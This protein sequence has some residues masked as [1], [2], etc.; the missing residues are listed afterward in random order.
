MNLMKNAL[1]LLL[2]CLLFSF[3]LA[4]QYPTKSLQA[5]R[6]DVPEMNVDGH[7][8]EPF[9]QTLE[10]HRDFVQYEPIENAAP[11]QATAF[12][13]AYDDNFIY[14]GFKAYDSSPD[15]IVHRLTRR[16][17]IDGDFVGVQFDSYF[18][19][20][21]A[22]T[23][24]AS[25]AGVKFD[26]IVSND[27]ENED[28]SWDPTWYVKNSRDQEG[29]YS[30][31]K[32]P[33]TQLRFKKADQ[34]TWGIQVARKLFRKDETIVWQPAARA[35]SGWVSQF[36]TLDNLTNLEPK[37]PLEIAPYVV[38]Q[39]DRY[40]SIAGDPYH[41]KGATNTLN[42]GVDGKLGLS[43]NFTL[44]FSIN[45][46]F[47]QVE[48]DPSRVNLTTQELFFEEKRL[49]FIEGKNIFNFPLLFG[50]GDLGSE[51]LFYSR[52]I[53]RR[54]HYD[55]NLLDGE[56]I[57][58]PEFTS[59]L[60]AA[61]LTGKTQ[62]GL[63]IGILESVTAEEHAAIST[64]EGPERKSTV[65]P[66]TNY[67]V[68]RVQK[69]FNA[70]NT[71]LGGMITSVNR[72]I[73]Q[74]YLQYLPENALTGGVDFTHKWKNRTYEFS[75]SNYFSRIQGSAESIESVQ[76]SFVH[77]FQ[78]PDQDYKILDPR[79]QELLGFGGKA[80]LG[81]FSGKLRFMAAMAWKSPGLEL[82]DAGYMP[83][84]DNLFEV[85]WVGYRV[86][87]PYKIFRNFSI[88]FNQW[89]VSD[90]GWENLGL[91]GNINLHTQF[92]NYWHLSTGMNINGQSLYTTALR[93]GPALLVPTTY[94]WWGYLST[95][96]QKPWQIGWEFSQ[97]W[98][99]ESYRKG[100][101][102]S[103]NF[104]Y[105]PTK[106]L[107]TSVNAYFQKNINELQYIDQIPLGE[108]T[109]Y[110]F[111]SIDQ[112]VLGMSLRLNYTI[113]PDL[114][115]QYWGQPFIAAARY[116][117]L[118]YITNAK[119]ATYNQRFHPY[120]PNEVFT[121]DDQIEFHEDGTATSYSVGTPDFNFKEFLSNLV[122]RWE[123]KPG[124][125]LYVVWSQTRSDAVSMGQ[126]NL[127]QDLDNLFA[128]DARNIFLVKASY[129][130]SR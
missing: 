114:T 129:R 86:Y 4:A 59:I 16:D 49:L 101:Y 89:Q 61:K 93:G 9:W 31:M 120:G 92:T 35:Q 102:Q 22:F 14:L 122:V 99:Q 34:Q 90:F 85:I 108:Q 130:F 125:V 48:A 116:D 1:G 64:S 53:G 19:H 38:A 110:L 78:R 13:L 91:G 96:D 21:T 50:D 39:T 68:G 33:L 23:F 112:N 40:A 80:L 124:S 20:R 56:Y 42:A 126:F 10:W 81:K 98:S 128:I 115:I 29:W 2:Y 8:N 44:D 27:G 45:P 15:S 127:G 25:A 95:N 104:S 77:N 87:K 11:S 83:E 57:K 41:N 66:L 88:N 72:Q 103:L 113:T 36:A 76:S 47:G 70:G 52:R 75:L 100:Y 17:D 51:N 24:V 58:S 117:A 65:E 84:A 79:K 67:L 105:R 7:F 37:L 12:A 3:S 18:D 119:A 94:N 32:I 46:D 69:D 118:K 28:P 54:P 121:R 55:P 82:N 26:F 43:N 5:V 106:S 63:S 30:E 107:Q 97:N 73:N 60:G 62:K 74:V 123:Y 109:R 6:V 111:G 71:I